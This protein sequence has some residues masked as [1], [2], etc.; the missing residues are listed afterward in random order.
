MRTKK[1]HDN[2]RNGKRIWRRNTFRPPHLSL[3]SSCVF[4]FFLLLLSEHYHYDRHQ[5]CHYYWYQDR[6]LH[7]MVFFPER[8]WQQEKEV[9]VRNRRNVK[10]K[11]LSLTK[12]RGVNEGRKVK[13]LSPSLPHPPP[14][15][16]T[17]TT[18]MSLGSVLQPPWST[19]PSPFWCLPPVYLLLSSLLIECPHLPLL[20][21]SEI[22]P[23]FTIIILDPCLVMV[24]IFVMKP[25]KEISVATATTTLLPSFIPQAKPTTFLT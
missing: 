21:L 19:W 18:M 5:E 13:P 20:L 24:R 1:L 12:R 22:T 7:H 6:N 4:F 15:L 9:H 14:S 16:I 17:I 8:W 25:L 3:S 10:K 23:R 11:M 2:N